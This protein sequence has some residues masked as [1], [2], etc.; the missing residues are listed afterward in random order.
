MATN[1]S[2]IQARYDAKHC[3]M[4]TMKFNYESDKDVIERLDSVPNKQDY[5]RQLVR[6]DIRSVPVSD[7]K[8]KDGE[9]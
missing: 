9:Q 1:K 3:K 7:S 8:Q 2:I 5:V 6:K 4:Y